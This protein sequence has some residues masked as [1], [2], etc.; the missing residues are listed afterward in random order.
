MLPRLP[1]KAMSHS[2]RFRGLTMGKSNLQQLPSPIPYSV[3]KPK[4]KMI[5]TS[6]YDRSLK[7]MNKIDK[8]VKQ[9]LQGRF[10]GGKSCG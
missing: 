7:E 4:V 5:G 10:I 3:P 8:C 1:Y 9:G 6:Q 2:N